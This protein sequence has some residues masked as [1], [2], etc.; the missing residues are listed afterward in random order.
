MLYPVNSNSM[1]MYDTLT[2]ADDAPIDDE[3]CNQNWQC[4]QESVGASLRIN[5]EGELEMLHYRLKEDVELSEDEQPTVDQVE[6]EWVM[7][8]EF[9]NPL[10]LN[11]KNHNAVLMIWDGVVE[12]TKIEEVNYDRF[13]EEVD[14]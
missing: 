7:F 14:I 2:V 9:N 3:I 4:N 1:S 5:S 10:Y 12:D 8:E 6:A 11:G 13:Q